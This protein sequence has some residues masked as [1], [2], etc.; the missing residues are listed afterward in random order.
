[1][2][3]AHQ[4]SRRIALF[5]EGDSERGEARRKTLAV[6]FH[7]WLD[8]QLPKGSKVGITPVKFQG[9]SNYLDDLPQKIALYL[10][11]QRANFVFGLVDLYGIPPSRIDLSEYGSVKEKVIAAREYIRKLVP[12]RYRGRFRQHFAVHEIEAWLLAYP[13]EWPVEI[14]A[15]LTRRDP[16]EVNFTEPPAK[17]LKRLL[18]GSYKKTTHALNLFPKIDPRVAID[19]CPYLRLLATDLLDIANRLQ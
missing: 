16:E 8:P 11:Y 13:Q 5:V 9:V 19:K 15:Q 14:R 6:F 2:N 17:F 4:K 3:N 7:K 1:M 10:D 18:G 12:E